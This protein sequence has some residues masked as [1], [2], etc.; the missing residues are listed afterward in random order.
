MKRMIWMAA[1]VAIGVLAVRKLSQ[2]RDA[3]G[4]AGLNRALG[5]VADSVAT[6]ADA[7]RDGMRERETD[8]RLALGID[9][10]DDVRTR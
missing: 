2:T 8:L 9:S 1:G 10:A 5:Q 6:F 7:V 3:L 4:P